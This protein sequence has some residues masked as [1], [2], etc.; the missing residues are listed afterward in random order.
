MVLPISGISDIKDFQTKHNSQTVRLE[1][2][3]TSRKEKKR[4]NINLYYE[5][6]P[7][8][9][10]ESSNKLNGHI[11]ELVFTTFQVHYNLN[12]H[13]LISQTV[14]IIKTILIYIATH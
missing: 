7:N 6:L 12:L 4:Q 14:H 13:D 5:Y 2:M 11:P 1:Y 10:L 8:I 9:I 3:P